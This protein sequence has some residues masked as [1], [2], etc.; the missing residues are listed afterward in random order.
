MRHACVLIAPSAI[1]LLVGCPSNNSVECRDQTSCDLAP[2]GVC[3]PAATG[4]QWCAYPDSTCPG[5]LRYS[6]GNIGDGLAGTCVESDVDAAIDAP[7]GPPTDGPP[8]DGNTATDWVETFGD[9]M[10]DSAY[11]AIGPDGSVYVAAAFSGT[12]M[13]G[14]TTLTA[15]HGV[16]VAVAKFTPT[17]TVAWA[18]RYGG[19]LDDKPGGIVVDASGN[20]IIAGEFYSSIDFGGGTLN[21][22]GT[23]DIFVAK[24]NGADGSHAWS[25]RYGGNAGDRAKRIAIDGAGDIAVAGLFSGTVSLGGTDLTS[26]GSLDVFI[27][28]YAGSNGSHVWSR[29]VGTNS[30]TETAAGV[31]F[32]GTDVVFVGEFQGAG[33]YGGPVVMSA[34]AADIVVA[35]YA[36]NNGAHLWSARHGGTS[37]DAALGVAASGTS[38]I[39]VVGEFSGMASLGGPTLSS[40]GLADAFAAKYDA[41]TGSHIWS[42]Q[43]GGTTGDRL[44]SASATSSGNLLAGGWFSGAAAVGSTTINSAGG[45]D[46]FL[47]ELAT[48]TGDVVTTSS[49]GGVNEDYLTT[50]TST[51]T[52]AVLAGMF[53]GSSSFYGFTK[54]SNGDFDGFVVSHAF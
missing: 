3:V 13:V 40:A 36:G 29:A 45:I 30:T 25:K 23:A 15:T 5:G 52:R 26:S 39:Y 33:A 21:S 41:A 8:I 22:A 10:E 4:N 46:S 32:V 27:A 43:F 17:G 35:R 38:S 34:G 49:F 24:L 9:G 11:A 47:V 6:D 18:R 44:V 42:K 19:T 50:V 7:D 54:T 20:P 51:G 14:S 1:A 53:R 2:G 28:K 37:Q 48:G 12:I 16:D 31:A